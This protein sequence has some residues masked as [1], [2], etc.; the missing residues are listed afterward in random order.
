MSPPWEW[1]FR[2]SRPHFG[3]IALWATLL[4]CIRLSGL[5]LPGQGIPSG[6]RL[7]LLSWAPAAVR[8][9]PALVHGAVVLFVCLALAW[10]VQALLP[11]SAVGAAAAFTVAVALTQEQSFFV[12][13]MFHLANLALWSLAL[14]YAICRKEIGAALAAGRFWMEP[15][16]PGWL[17]ALLVFHVA[18]LYG[19]AGISKLLDSG[20]DWPNGVSL[21]LWVLLWGKPGAV[22]TA[23]LS[24]RALAQALQWGA[25]SAEVSALPLAF[26]RRG[27][28]A[29]ALA[30]LGFH[31]GQQ[32]IFGWWFVGNM[33]VIALALLPIHA[34]VCARVERWVP[35][36]LPFP[37]GP[38]WLWTRLDARG[39]YAVPP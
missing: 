9:N 10:M 22:K 27:R 13:H 23:I 15:L 34:F 26:L 19:L 28:I 21:Q 31:V 3:V 35:R 5:L 1:L 36:G 29:S 20:L 4:A 37:P 2:R 25:L 11:W 16:L 38:R 7:T 14:W 32:V 33:V 8:L 30:L 12:D 6:D 39:R 18:W 24:S 17:H